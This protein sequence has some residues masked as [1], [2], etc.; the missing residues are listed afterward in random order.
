MTYTASFTL[1]KLFLK[2]KNIKSKKKK[3]KKNPIKPR[4]EMEI[5]TNLDCA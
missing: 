5:L 1:G 4:F 2:K 3:G